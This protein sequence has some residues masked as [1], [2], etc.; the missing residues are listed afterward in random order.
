MTVKQWHHENVNRKGMLKSGG[1]VSIKKRI[2]FSSKDGCTI[3]NCKCGKGYWVCIN[4][5]YNTE[6]KSVTGTT[7]HFDSAKE[8][9]AF[10]KN[11]SFEL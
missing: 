6:K 11:S 5:G 8:Y 2:T 4:L 3:E 10:I 7:L 1:G 9:N